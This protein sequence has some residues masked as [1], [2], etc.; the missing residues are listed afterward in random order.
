[1]FERKYPLWYCRDVSVSGGALLETARSGIWYTDDIRLSG[2]LVAAPK[3]FRRGRGISLR[4]VNLPHAEET[5][6]SCREITLEDL[7]GAGARLHRRQ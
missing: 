6:W 2:T 3:T 4:R 7:V 1:M 5:L